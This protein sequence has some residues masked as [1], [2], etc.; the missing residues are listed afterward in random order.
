MIGFIGTYITI[1]LTY[2]R[3]YQ[4][5]ISDCLRLAPFLTGLRLSS[6]PTWF[7]WFWFTSG[8]LLQLRCL[9]VN[10]PQLNTQSRLQSDWLTNELV[11][12]SSTTESINYLSSFYNF[13]RTKHRTPSRTVRQLYSVYPLLW[14]RV[15]GEPLS[16]NVLFRLSGVMSQ[17]N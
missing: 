9:L 16:S 7:T 17:Y 14:I 12:D 8:S 1:T 3:L 2:N 5:I 10:T 11:D 4:L 15:F 13:G 6:L